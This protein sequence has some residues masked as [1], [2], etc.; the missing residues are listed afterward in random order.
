MR[1]LAKGDLLCEEGVRSDDLGFINKGLLRIVYRGRNGEFVTKDFRSEGDFVGAYSALLRK[2][3]AAFSIEAL[4]PCEIVVLP[5]TDLLTAYTRHPS[6]QQI[7][8]LI[9][10]SLYV[11][12][13]V[14]ERQLLLLTATERFAAF[15][16]ESRPL[17]ARLSQQHIA[18][19]L[20][21]SPVS[22]S[23]LQ[24]QHKAREL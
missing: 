14:R 6:W 17:L 24:R 13:E 12:R 22:L 11:E 15:R 4:E 23:R 8:R 18:S 9:A 10:E 16:R 1:L 3:P 21:I 5:F 7:G 2:E 20:G 19:Y